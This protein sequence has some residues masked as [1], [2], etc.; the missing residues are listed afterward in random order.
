MLA[1][2]LLK[3]RDSERARLWRVFAVQLAAADCGANCSRAR[4][5]STGRPL[6]ICVTRRAFIGVIRW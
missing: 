5:S 3:G 1:A 4:A 6:I 2:R